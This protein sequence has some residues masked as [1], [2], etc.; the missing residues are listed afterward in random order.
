MVRRPSDR[1][2]GRRVRVNVRWLEGIIED[3]QLALEL[4][5]EA[6]RRLLSTTSIAYARSLC[7]RCKGKG[8]CGRPDCPFLKAMKLFSSYMPDLD[9]TE[10]EGNSPPAVFVGRFGYPYVSVGP[11]IPPV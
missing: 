6:R 9:S 2:R 10:L 5:P 7:L 3:P 4:S 1:T 11:L 8:L